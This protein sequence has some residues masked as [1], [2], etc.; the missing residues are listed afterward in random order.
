MAGGQLGQPAIKSARQIVA[1]F[2]KLFLNDIKIIDQPFGCGGDRAALL[3]GAGR[4]AIILQQDASIF[5]NARNER[6]ALPDI[7]RGDL[8]SGEIFGVLLETFCAEQFAA[9]WPF[10]LGKQAHRWDRRCHP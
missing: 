8:G 10:R 1:N 9:N 6:P 7:L 5:Q 2:A 3:N 4:G